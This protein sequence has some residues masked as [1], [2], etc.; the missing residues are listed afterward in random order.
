MGSVLHGASIVIQTQ[1]C[2]GK[3]VVLVL[4]RPDHWLT[5]VATLGQVRFLAR[6][7]SS[8]P[9]NPS[10]QA[11]RRSRALL[12]RSR[13]MLQVLRSRAKMGSVLHG[14]QIV[15]QRQYCHGKS[16]VLVLRRP[17]PWLTCVATLDRVRS[18]ADSSAPFNPSAQATAMR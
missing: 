16:A 17:D 11:T 6:A 4:R 8:A 9:F 14:A 12:Q 18:Q 10:A 7:D 3:S 15:I 13:A 5:C 1:Y 2:H